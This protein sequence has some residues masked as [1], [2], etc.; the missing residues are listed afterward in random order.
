[1]GKVD[2]HLQVDAALLADAEKKG[3]RL[4]QALEE[5]IRAALLRPRPDRAMTIVEAAEQLKRSP[6]DMEAAA[7]QW[8]EE[9]AAAIESHKKFIEE[10]GVFGDDLRTW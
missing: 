4:D 5:G 7:R 10:F 6:I 2:L 8:A 1:M 3:V 9:N